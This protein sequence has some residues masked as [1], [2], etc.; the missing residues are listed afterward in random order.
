[1]YL[2]Y[3]TLPHLR[4]TAGPEARRKH[5]AALGTTVGPWHGAGRAVYLGHV[6]FEL[7]GPM[8]LYKKE[9][10]HVTSTVMLS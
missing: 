2:K 1:M 7:G 9:L 5:P 6:E 10:L 3:D 8:S 4:E